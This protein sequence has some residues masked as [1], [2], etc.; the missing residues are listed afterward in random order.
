MQTNQ[1]PCPYEDGS[2]SIP[3]IYSAPR[4]EFFFC[5]AITS[6]TIEHAFVTKQLYASQETV[7]HDT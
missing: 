1:R 5:L 6:K 3:L 4:V 7:N 2:T